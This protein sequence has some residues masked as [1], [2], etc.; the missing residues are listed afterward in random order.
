MLYEYVMLFQS[1]HSETL[2]TFSTFLTFISRKRKNA[3]L[4]F[5]KKETKYVVYPV[6]CAV[7]KVVQER[8]RVSS[9]RQSEVECP[10]PKFFKLIFDLKML[11]FDALL[12]V[13]YAI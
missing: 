5:E 7:L 9:L 11:S 10:L 3:F 4:N 1:T 6:M 8:S 13:F 12:V 2:I